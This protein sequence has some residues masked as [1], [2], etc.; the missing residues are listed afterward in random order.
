MHAHLRVRCCVF[1]LYVIVFIYFV[2]IFFLHS[3]YHVSLITTNQ[4]LSHEI[5]AQVH[6]NDDSKVIIVNTYRE[7]EKEIGSK[8]K[9]EQVSTRV[10]G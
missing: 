8:M 7:Q 10:S 3:D 6:V 1:V 4:D 2:Y 9:H 5:T